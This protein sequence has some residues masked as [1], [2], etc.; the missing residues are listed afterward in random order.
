[1]FGTVQSIKFHPS[2]S[3]PVLALAMAGFIHGS[4][5]AG[6]ITVTF[7]EIGLPLPDHRS[8][9]VTQ[10]VRFSPS[11]HQH[12]DDAGIEFGPPAPFG[13]YLSWDQ[14]GCYVN[15]NPNIGNSF[16]T[17]YLGPSGWESDIAKMYVE[18]ESRDLF[19]L[20]SLIFASRVN[21]GKYSVTSSKG[22]FRIIDGAD[23][24][25]TTRSFAGDEWADV[26]W[27]EFVR[28]AGSDIPWGFD[29]LA[30]TSNA[31]PE[32]SSYGLAAL[33]LFGLI[34]GRGRRG[35][36]PTEAAA[37]PATTRA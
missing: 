15:P 14:S 17:N 11:C 16:N 13:K 19:S 6:S 8:N 30:L 12:I 32:P 7:D 2:R 4:A 34:V 20:E 25:F 18:L 29:N 23:G 28:I 33:A 21:G 1:M 37:L 36:R 5:M 26:R 3:L 22:G 31:V 35:A 24:V 9:F 10:G 27:L